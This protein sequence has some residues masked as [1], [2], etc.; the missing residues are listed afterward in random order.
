MIL[1]NWFQIT[2]VLVLYD[3]L[4]YFCV[5]NMSFEPLNIEFEVQERLWKFQNLACPLER[6]NR[7]SSMKC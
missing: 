1:V 3:V 5:K 7:R 2:H 6:G 4:P